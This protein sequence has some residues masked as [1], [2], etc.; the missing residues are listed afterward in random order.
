VLSFL[1]LP[2]H[3]QQQT[4]QGWRIMTQLFY[5]F[6]SKRKVFQMQKTVES[7]NHWLHPSNTTYQMRDI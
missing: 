2:R 6:H 4:S 3:W 1:L 5:G 7:I